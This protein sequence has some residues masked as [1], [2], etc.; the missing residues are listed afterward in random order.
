MGHA[1]YAYFAGFSLSMTLRSIALFA[2][3]ILGAGAFWG[4]AP[5]AVAA[6]T[7]GVGSRVN[8]PGSYLPAENGK[9]CQ[10]APD[11][12]DIRYLG[13]KS[14]QTCNFPYTRVNA[15]ES[16]WCVTYPDY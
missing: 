10:A 14:T 16:K 15:G 1:L 6:T 3:P 7:I 5:Y 12:K 2:L 8:C 13:E 9:V 4:C 11:F